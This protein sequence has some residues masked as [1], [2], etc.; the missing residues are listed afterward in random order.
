MWQVLYPNTWVEPAAN[1]FGTYVE[2]PGFIDS[3]GSGSR[4]GPL[5]YLLLL[6]MSV[7][8]ALAPFHSDN[9][10]TL[11][12]SDTVRSTRS[13]G[14]TYPEVVDWNVS[15]ADLSSS[16]R[17]EVNSLYNPNAGNSSAGA[18]SGT[19]ASREVDVAESFGFVTIDLAKELGVN[20]L[21]TQWSINI[22]LQR[23]AYPTA[24]T[25]HFFMG[26]APTDPSLWPAAPNL[27]GT[28]AQFIAADVSM[29]Y[30]N[31]APTG[32]LQG[33]IS[34]THTLAAGVS[35]GLL[36]D[37]T[38]ASVLPLLAESLNWRARAA[39]G[40]AIDIDSLADLSIAVGSRQ[41]QPATSIDEFPIYGDT[42]YHAEATQGK[43]GGIGQN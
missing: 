38:P 34:L 17:T 35:R 36:A 21:D 6:I 29:M 32:L 19:I 25:I 26:N 33:E 18:T 5:L 43:C 8:L 10:S 39:D 4:H 20:N 12:T 13:F 7:H 41:V 31:G 42:Q 23:Y 14:Y 40:C 24:F 9:R 30:P 15:A 3:A 37:L 16:V 22:Q 11:Y 1:T 28:H 2:A 27:I